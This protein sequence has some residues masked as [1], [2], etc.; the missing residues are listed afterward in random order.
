VV[1]P[2][3]RIAHQMIIYQRQ[4]KIK[5]ESFSICKQELAYFKELSNFNRKLYAHYFESFHSQKEKQAHLEELSWILL[6][7]GKTHYFYNCSTG[8]AISTCPLIKS[9]EYQYL[10][11]IIY[12]HAQAIKLTSSNARIIESVLQDIA[13]IISSQ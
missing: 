11:I 3:Y 8:E 4:C 1:T 6:F 12:K 13:K 5:Q 9:N 10:S 2:S 7:N